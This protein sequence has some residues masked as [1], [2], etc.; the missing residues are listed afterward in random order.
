MLVLRIVCCNL[1]LQHY[2][3][4]TRFRI[5]SAVYYCDNKKKSRNHV[6]SKSFYFFLIDVNMSDLFFKLKVLFAVACKRQLFSV[7]GATDILFDTLV[8]R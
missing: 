7:S 8:N 2:L 1:F 3:K 4:S 5:I 6:L